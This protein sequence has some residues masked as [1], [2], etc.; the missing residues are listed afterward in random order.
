MAVAALFAPVAAAVPA[1]PGG[2][3][4]VAGIESA[5]VVAVGRIEDVERVDTHAHRASLRVTRSLRGAA[6]V[7][8]AVTVAWEELAPS[9]PTRLFTSVGS[10]R[11]WA[12]AWAD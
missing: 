3:P 12:L 10:A 8:T 4:L 11:S 5:E 7:G 9:R 6:T 2:A 1:A